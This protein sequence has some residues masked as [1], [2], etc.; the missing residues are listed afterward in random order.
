MQ[1]LKIIFCF[2]LHRLFLPSNGGNFPP[3]EE[4]FCGPTILEIL[5]VLKIVFLVP[6]LLRSSVFFSKL[7]I[8]FSEFYLENFY[9]PKTNFL[10]FPQLQL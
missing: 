4:R 7:K 10:L 3:L 8:V 9:P 5:K 2:I 6:L 1:S